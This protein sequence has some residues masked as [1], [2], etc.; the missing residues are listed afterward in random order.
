MLPDFSIML[1]ESPPVYENAVIPSR[2]GFRRCAVPC[3]PG[4]GTPAENYLRRLVRSAGCCETWS[5]RIY[6][7][8]SAN[9]A[10]VDDIIDGILSQYFEEGIECLAQG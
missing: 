3:K 9:I 8:Q 7:E 2:Q 10:L 4:Q 1:P 6:S 5:Q